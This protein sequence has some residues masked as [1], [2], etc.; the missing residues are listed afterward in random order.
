MST[1]AVVVNFGQPK[2]KGH[3]PT[4]M[5]ESRVLFRRNLHLAD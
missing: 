3:G 2:L 5:H 1:I 4:G